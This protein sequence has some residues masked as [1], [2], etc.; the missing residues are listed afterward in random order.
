MLTAGQCVTCDTNTRDDTFGTVAYE[1]T[2]VNLPC[3][4]KGCNIEDGVEFLMLGGT[5]PAA[6]QGVI[7]R[8]CGC[9]VAELMAKKKMRV[10][11]NTVKAK[12]SGPAE[13]RRVSPGGVIELD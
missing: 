5:G 13:S 12:Y 4:R 8:D 6:R 2:K 7:I 3:P 9:H 10:V 11:P 1:V